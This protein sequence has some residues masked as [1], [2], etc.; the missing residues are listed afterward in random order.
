MIKNG[1]SSKC[2]GIDYRW[3]LCLEMDCNDRSFK[4]I[5]IYLHHHVWQTIWAHSSGAKTWLRIRRHCW[6]AIIKIMFNMIDIFFSPIV[7]EWSEILN[8]IPPSWQEHLGHWKYHLD[9]QCWS[10]STQKIYPDRE[11]RRYSDAMLD[12][13]PCFLDTVH[14][15][16]NFRGI[17]LSSFFTLHLL[18]NLNLIYLNKSEIPSRVFEARLMKTVH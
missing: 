7:C 13:H 8:L 2:W 17:P 1:I 14:R 10:A 3:I 11:G 12:N 4:L 6:E 15:E 16:D 5:I 18:R 9:F